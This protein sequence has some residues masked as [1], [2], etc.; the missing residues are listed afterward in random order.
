MCYNVFTV[1]GAFCYSQF[2][3]QRDDG[4][5]D[6][7]IRLLQKEAQRKAAP[8]SM[9]RLDTRQWLEMQRAAPLRIAVAEALPVT[10]APAVPD[11]VWVDSDYVWVDSDERDQCER[12]GSCMNLQR[13]AVV[14]QVSGG[15][16][17]SSGSQLRHCIV[18]LLPAGTSNTSERLSA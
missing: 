7:F 10:A 2:A 4:S 6:Q 8:V 12:W 16:K 14:C 17:N 9:G 18:L 1:A 3:P 13:S 5:Y 15:N 11:Y